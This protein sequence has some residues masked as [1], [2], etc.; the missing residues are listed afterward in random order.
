[1]SVQEAQNLSENDVSI[2]KAA[3]DALKASRMRGLFKTV[4]NVYQLFLTAAPSLCKNERLFSAL[5][6]V[7]NYLRSIMSADRLNDCMLLAV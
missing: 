1:M 7:K 3:S 2:T 5:K 4:A 6:R